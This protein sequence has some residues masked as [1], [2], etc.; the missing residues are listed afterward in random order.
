ME[1]K[2]PRSPSYPSLSL[3]AAIDKVRDVQTNYRTSSVDRETLAR[4]MGYTGLS[5]ASLQALASLTAY[6]LLEKQG[7]GEA[8]V[9]D[10]AMRILFAESADELMVA[11]RQAAAS[12]TVFSQIAEKFDGHVPN[13]EGIVSFLRRNGFTENAAETAAQT[14][15][16]SMNFV[17]SLEDGDR[18]GHDPE[19]GEKSTPSTRSEEDR[20][21]LQAT[22]N[23]EF[24]D[25]VRGCTVDGAAFRLLV[26]AEFGEEQWGDAMEILNAQ[27]NII[28]RR[29]AAKGA[30]LTPETV[31]DEEN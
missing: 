11:K 1:A 2:R 13:K 8:R 15:V 20:T 4:A 24:K 17:A 31:T 5:G 9:T 18:T 19:S 25:L 12:P 28:K 22:P 21:M 26:N 3:E 7:K 16:E 30:K 10:L 27:F 14:Y 6:G 29:S 23:G